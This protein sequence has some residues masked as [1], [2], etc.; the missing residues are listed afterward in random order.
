MTQE[1]TQA[2]EMLLQGKQFVLTGGLNQY[3]RKEAQELIERLG[4]RVS[5]SVSKKTD[6]VLAGEDPGSKYDKAQALGVR[7]IDEQEFAEIIKQSD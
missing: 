7:I 1:S 6:F 4:G 2:A 3:T 5:S